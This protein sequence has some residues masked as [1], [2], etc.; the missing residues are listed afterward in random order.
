MSEPPEGAQEVSEWLLT[1][2]LSQYT[3]SFLG[4]GY[5]T[6]DDCRELTEDRLLELDVLPTGHRR[7]MLRSLEALRVTRPSGE[8]DEGAA[9]GG[10]RTR[11]V[12]NPRHIFLDKKRGLSYQHHQVKEK[13]D[14]EG[15]RTLPPGSGLVQSDDDPQPGRVRPPQPA[16]RKPENI[17]A[18]PYEPAPI[19]PS[20]SSC[21]SSSESPTFSEMPSDWDV[22]PEDPTQ[23]SSDSVHVSS[24]AQD[25]GGF[26]CEMVEN[27][28]YEA[29]PGVARPRPT[30][31]YRLRH[32]PVP[33]IPSLTPPQLR[34]R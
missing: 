13:K 2:R 17:Q 15:S 34:E 23:S 21:S 11:P 14:P 1:L 5:R 25:R 29:Q 8:E 30:R 7:R 22:S 18:V 6:L 20:V 24:E 19:P 28:I 33:K 32:R 3:S 12:P 31:S 26:T 9:N 4:A 16:L 27:S 10:P